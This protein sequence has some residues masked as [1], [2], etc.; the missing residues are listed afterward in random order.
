MMTPDA[1][2]IARIYGADALRDAFDEAVSQPMINGHA[3]PSKLLALPPWWR[4]PAT[5]PPR[6]H[7]FGRH[8]IRRAM[9]ATIA[10]GGRAKTT[11]ACSE[12]VT[13]ST[14]RDPMT[15]T[16][17]S[18][19]PLSV[20][21]LNGEEDQDELDR[22]TA[23][24]CQRYGIIEADLGGRLFVQSVRDCPMRIATIVNGQ[25]VINTATQEQMTEFIKANQIDVFMIDPLVSFH[26][27]VENDNSHMDMVVKQGFGAIANKTNSAGEL[28]HHPGKPKP[29]QTDT[30][31]E[32]GRGASALLW[33]VRSARVLNFM[34]P[35]EADR[36]GMS[37]EERRLH[38]RVANGKANMAPLGKAE[39]MK[40]EVELLPNG[41]KLPASVRGNRQT[42]SKTSP[43]P[44]WNWRRNW[45]ALAHT[46]TTRARRNGSATR[47]PVASISPFPTR[48]PTIR[49]T[50]PSSS[51]SSKPGRTTRFWAL[52]GGPV[53]TATRRISSCPAQPPDRRRPAAIQMTMRPQSNEYT[54]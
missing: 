32:D 48:V 21:L 29:G 36:L 1:N 53:K 33:A 24:H 43:L 11:L 49:R 12:A 20:W 26:G 6:Q 22:R 25:P 37:E 40:I 31:V 42:P 19:G 28:F 17:L 18:S 47:S 7:L 10:A 8:Y 15:G 38:V 13:M 4:D 34:T 44:T 46:A 54:N 35:A 16:A 50:S 41:I 2:D 14:G 27:V 9:A 23:A 30:T 3:V 52:S 45:R 5:I 51:P 39:W